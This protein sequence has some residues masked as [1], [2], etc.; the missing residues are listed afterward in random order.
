MKKYITLI[1]NFIFLVSVFVGPTWG[2]EAPTWWPQALKD[3]QKGG[4]GL[5]TPQEAQ[6][7]YASGED[8]LMVDVRPDYEFKTGHL[9]EAKNFEIDL[10]D[11][12]EL[13]PKKADAFR[14]VL[15]DDKNREIVIYCRSFR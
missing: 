11:R 5:T 2:K 3:A 6:A 4:Y 10:G 13:K 12:L 8:F 9:P 1:L 14:K 15:G 7:L